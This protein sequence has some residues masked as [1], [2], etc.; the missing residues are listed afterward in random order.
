MAVEDDAEFQD[1]NRKAKF[2][3]KLARLFDREHQVLDDLD[4]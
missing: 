2:K 1:K 4:E 3:A